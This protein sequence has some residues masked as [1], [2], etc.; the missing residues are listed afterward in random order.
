MSFHSKNDL[1]DMREV[2]QKSFSIR[3]NK[4]R[5]DA[6]Q[7]IRPKIKMKFQSV[8]QVTFFV[9]LVKIDPLLLSRRHRK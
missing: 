3:K 7:C 9:S 4:K 2:I 6:N 5:A 1:A 8:P